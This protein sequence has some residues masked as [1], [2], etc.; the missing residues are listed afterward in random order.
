MRSTYSASSHNCN[1]SFSVLK[2]W[3]FKCTGGR[4]LKHLIALT[5]DDF[6]KCEV[7]KA[8]WWVPHG[9]ALNK[10][11]Q[12]KNIHYWLHPFHSWTKCFIDF[13]WEGESACIWSVHII[14]MFNY[15]WNQCKFLYFKIYLNKRNTRELLQP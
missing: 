12:R 8:F 11:L 7:L 3:A 14:L 6:S 2:E 1:A 5:W 13:Y 4:N 10:L 9:V 15:A